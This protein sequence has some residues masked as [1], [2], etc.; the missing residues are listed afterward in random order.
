MSL[1]VRKGIDETVELITQSTGGDRLCEEGTGGKRVEEVTAW[2]PK[3]TKRR[4]EDMGVI[5]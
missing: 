2:K 4:H 5:Q 1:G 3:H